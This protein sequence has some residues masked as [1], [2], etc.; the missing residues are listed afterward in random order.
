MVTWCCHESLSNGRG[1]PLSCHGTRVSLWLSAVS[2]R[3]DGKDLLPASLFWQE[4]GCNS[5]W[6]LLTRGT[7]RLAL[8]SVFMVKCITNLVEVVAA[9]L[10]QKMI[11]QF[12]SSQ[13][14]FQVFLR[15]GIDMV[16]QNRDKRSISFG[17]CLFL[18]LNSSMFRCC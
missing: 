16:L 5:P 4:Q 18:F 8:C 12:R 13:S 14:E 10:P 15:K 7:D 1:D 2:L 17:F 3:E 6:C 9:F 11:G